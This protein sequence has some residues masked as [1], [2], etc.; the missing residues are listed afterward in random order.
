MKSKKPRIIWEGKIGGDPNNPFLLGKQKTDKPMPKKE[1]LIKGG[2]TLKEMK[3]IYEKLE[4]ASKC[5]KHGI[6][7]EFAL[8][9]MNICPKCRE[10]T[11]PN[12]AE[13]FYET[14]NK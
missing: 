2:L 12:F 7:Y 4:K 13:G 10:I 9:P 11:L 8:V 14:K 5:P 3:R 1:K 6:K